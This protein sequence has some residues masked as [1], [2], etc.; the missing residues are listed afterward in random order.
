MS[1]GVARCALALAMDRH[2]LCEEANWSGK[3]KGE[4]E[5]VGFDKR[6]GLGQ[7]QIAVW[8]KVEAVGMLTQRNLRCGLCGTLQCRLFLGFITAWAA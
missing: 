2:D 5:V 3:A 7:G 1:I 8:V 4:A 6:H